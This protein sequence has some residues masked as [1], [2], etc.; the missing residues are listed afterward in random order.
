M[1]GLTSIEPKLQKWLINFT[2]FT[3]QKN[4]LANELDRQ[5]GKKSISQKFIE[6][7]VAAS[8]KLFLANQIGA[9]N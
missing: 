6:E 8:N 2:V 5:P 9:H 1:C 4:P 7:V 3:Q